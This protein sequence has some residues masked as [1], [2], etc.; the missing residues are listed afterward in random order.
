MSQTSQI[1]LSNLKE[2][3][4]KETA[5]TI[6]PLRSKGESLLNEIRNRLNE[7]IKA[8]EKL[9]EK[10]EKEIEKASPKTYR[11]AKLANKFSRNLIETMSRVVVPTQLSYANLQA[12]YVNLEKMQA[13]VDHERRICYH[14]ISPY[15]I[16]DRR[17]LDAHLKRTADALPELRDFLTHKYAKAK[18]VDEA[19]SEVDKLLQSL[20]EAE[21]NERRTKQVELRERFL[22]NNLVENQQKMTLIEG[23]AELAELIKTNEKVEELR[24]TVKH[25]LRH[26]QKPFYKLQSLSRGSEVA[27]PLD[28][29]KKLND[30]LNDPFEALAAEEEGHPMLK[31]IL[32]K[33]DDSI[34]QGKLKLK[35]SRLRKAQEQINSILNKNALVPLQQSCVQA[36]ALRKQLLTSEVVASV[37]NELARL[38]NEK[39]ELQ[40]RIE[41]IT[42]RKTAL[43]NERNGLQG[44]IEQQK[45]ELEKLVFQLTG[46]TVQIMLD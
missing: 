20:T 42:S 27:L 18:T 31:K 4:Q 6:E 37:Q 45:K 26:L 16:L 22:E 10:S 14:F 24:E 36:H 12:L 43:I 13:T 44:K 7:A 25:N 1:H 38:Q 15:F 39:R 21:E 29:A 30:Y 11:R 35:S 34:N 41:L 5:Q 33:V 17:W 2:W 8:S 32:R 46:K 3:I 28:E 9:V 40:R 19:L 23:K